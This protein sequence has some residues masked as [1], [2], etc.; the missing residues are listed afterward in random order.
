LKAKYCYHHI[1]QDTTE[2]QQA[3][4]LSEKK[5]SKFLFVGIPILVKQLGKIL[6]GLT[7]QKDKKLSEDGF[8]WM[9]KFLL[10]IEK[11][12]P[13]FPVIEQLRVELVNI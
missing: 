1:P 4:T 2:L 7:S 3:I 9:A 12:A 8:Y 6:Q 5:K 13:A 11:W 10:S